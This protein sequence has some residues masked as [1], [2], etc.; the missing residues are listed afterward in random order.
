MTRDEAYAGLAKHMGLDLEECHFGWFDIEQ[1]KKAK[2]WAVQ[3][4]W[5]DR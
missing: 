1:C 3:Q 5:S 4:Q 2:A